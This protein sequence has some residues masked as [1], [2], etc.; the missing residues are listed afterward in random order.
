M[1]YYSNQQR[2][3]KTI[4]INTTYDKSR[5]I[6][7][8]NL[9]EVTGCLIRMEPDTREEGIKIRLTLTCFFPW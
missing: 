5:K 3:K 8:D 6:C 7:F 2:A 9:I 4:N 1:Y